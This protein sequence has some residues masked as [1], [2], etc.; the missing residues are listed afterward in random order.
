[1]ELINDAYRY[2]NDAKEMDE[3]SWSV[4]REAAEKTVIL[5]SPV[6]PH[7]TEELWHILG[8]E[9]Y[10][11]DTGWPGYNEG[12]LEKDKRRIVVQVNGKVRSKM[13]VPAFLSDKE[14]E[15][16]ALE[17]EKVKAFIG[18]KGIKKIFVVQQK[19]VNI[20]I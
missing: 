7:I 14:I 18:E 10:L 8:H 12:A 6:V 2:M 11:I 19:L 17:D 16:K 5:L 15:A 3:S 1:M 4:I 13:E 20:V 9:G